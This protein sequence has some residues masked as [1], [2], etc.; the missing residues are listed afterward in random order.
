MCNVNSF[1]I[2]SASLK[3][4]CFASSLLAFIP[5]S[6]ATEDMTL[7]EDTQW[8]EVNIAIFKQNTPGFQNEQWRDRDKLNLQFPRRTVMLDD[9]SYDNINFDQ[10]ELE[11]YIPDVPSTPVQQLPTHVTSIQ[12][13]SSDEQPLTDE[14]KAFFDNKELPPKITAF[15]SIDT[16]DREFKQTLRRLR[17][18]KAYK[19][20]TTKTWRQPGLAL[21]ASI[22]VLI[23]A[24]EEF[25]GD[26][27][28]EGTV[29]ISLSRYLHVQ[30][31]LWL[32][33]YVK[34]IELSN[35]WWEESTLE[36]A[37]TFEGLLTD[38]TYASE[39]DEPG[40]QNLNDTTT[41]HSVDS[42]S[43][44]PLLSALNINESST[45]YEA[46]RTVV[47]D[48]SRRMRSNELHYLDHP[49]FGMVIKI[50]SYEAPA[51]EIE[52]ES[53]AI[54]STE[55][56]ANKENQTATQKTQPSQQKILTQ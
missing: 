18:S 19:I 55:L 28:L 4:L 8:Y 33:E 23:Q 29:N 11:P 17:N 34:Q 2:L 21:S 16:E 26:Y 38:S 46:I 14:E 13:S 40:E 41:L 10:I 5:H 9:E 42:N 31:N 48:E 30:S 22:P 24:G 25:D 15:R 45:H 56:P 27:E 7:A 20:L 36:N 49:L 39:T 12:M 47:I 44:T 37:P 35:T 32:S 6:Y 43:S 50:T 53:L 1:S 52:E 51:P 54:K 3:K